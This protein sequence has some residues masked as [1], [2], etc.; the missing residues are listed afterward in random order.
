MS[1]RK[2]NI[3]ILCMILLITLCIF[4]GYKLK[5]SS[6]LC[7]KLQKENINL[8]KENE[9]IKS[10]SFDPLHHILPDEDDELFVKDE[11]T[12]L[13]AYFHYK[14]LRYY[15]DTNETYKT[16]LT[17]YISKKSIND[18]VIFYKPN[19][20][21]NFIIKESENHEYYEILSK[22]LK[23]IR[24][25]GSGTGDRYFVYKDGYVVSAY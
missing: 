22:S 11:R 19:K 16:D 24:N 14:S 5:S 1:L 7:N 6:E 21:I 13:L 8:K 12:A 17:D 10:D 23:G 9:N 3:C 15:S 18:Y 20:D 4:M 25:G 2:K